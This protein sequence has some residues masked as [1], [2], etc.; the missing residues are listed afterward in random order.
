M[1]CVMLIHSLSCFGVRAC[2]T[3]RLHGPSIRRVSHSTCYAPL[4]PVPAS[5]LYY[6]CFDQP[7]G[8]QLAQ[9]VDGPVR[10]HHTP[11][12]RGTAFPSLFPPSLPLCPS[13]PV[14]LRMCQ[15]LAGIDAVA[16][17]LCLRAAEMA[18]RR[19]GPRSP[20]SRALSVHELAAPL[21]PAVA[22]DLYLLLRELVVVHCEGT[23]TYTPEGWRGGM[24]TRRAI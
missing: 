24:P 18:G 16:G 23:R 10:S 7:E 21:G 19:L 11:P 5:M 20:G 14:S 15:T 22:G 1:M 13:L 6:L 17:S 2:L 4:A 12:V 8:P 9:K 3:V